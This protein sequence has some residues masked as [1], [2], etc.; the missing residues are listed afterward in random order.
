MLTFRTVFYDRLYVSFRDSFMIK[1]YNL[2]KIRTKDRILIGI[3]IVRQE[4]VQ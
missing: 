2:R 1:K 4:Q 3:F